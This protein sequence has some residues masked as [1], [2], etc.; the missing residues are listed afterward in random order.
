MEFNGKEL[1]NLEHLAEMLDQ[2]ASH[3]DNP[4][5]YMHFLLDR[6]KEVVLHIRKSFAIAPDILT[7]YAIGQARSMDLPT[8]ATPHFL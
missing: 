2:L 4:D 1:L 7:Q 5:G 6:D 3:C 8:P